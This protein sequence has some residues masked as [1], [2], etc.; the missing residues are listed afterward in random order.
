MY[1]NSNSMSKNLVKPSKRT[2]GGRLLLLGAG[3]VCIAAVL[4]KLL[5]SPPEGLLTECRSNLHNIPAALSMYAGDWNGQF[6]QTLKQLQPTYM[7]LV[8]NCPASDQPYTYV[9]DSKSFLQNGPPEPHY[10]LSCTGVS[11]AA[12]GVSANSPSYDSF[13]DQVKV[14]R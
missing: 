6:P 10:T 12:A 5:K 13:E 7:K 3:I 8:P 11:H 4:P 2:Y 14:A 9:V 1:A